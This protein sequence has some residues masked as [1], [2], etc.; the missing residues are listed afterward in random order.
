MVC[1]ADCG[2]EGGASLKA[3]TACKLV[4]YC[5]VNC[6]K[7]HWPKHKKA[8]KQRAAELRDEALFKDPPAKEECPICFLPMPLKLV[9]CVSLPPATITSGV[10]VRDFANANK[11]LDKVNTEQ[12]YTCCGK[13]ICRGCVNSFCRSGNYMNCPYCKSEQY[14][15]TDEDKVEDLMKR[16]E[17]ND[18]NSIYVLGT[19]YYDGSGGLEQ[20]HA[21]AMVLYARAAELGCSQAHYRLG[22]QFDDV[23]DLKK[24][25][26]HYEAAAMA[27]QETARN[28]LGYIEAQ[29][30]NRERAVK[31]LKIAASAG[32][33]Y[34]MHSVLDAFEKGYVSREAMN[35]TLAAYN[36]SCVEMRSEARDAAIRIH[37]DGSIL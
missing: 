37:I 32:H 2:E 14:R 31:H 11:E 29:F 12:Y 5:N 20:D 28:N 35:S 17:V 3:C 23:G 34:A 33:Y 13:S 18:A 16:V 22:V 25:K 9:C 30:G 19:W 6:Q 10:P 1:C 8:C 4:K 26:F 21:K 7:N 36:N 15:K 24:A 27:G